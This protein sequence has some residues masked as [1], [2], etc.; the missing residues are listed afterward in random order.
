MRQIGFQMRDSVVGSNEELSETDVRMP[1]PLPFESERIRIGTDGEGGASLALQDGMELQQAALWLGEA[2]ARD[3][4]LLQVLDSVT[5]NA[6]TIAIHV[7]PALAE[8]ELCRVT[9]PW[10]LA[11]VESRD[12]RVI[13]HPSGEAEIKFAV[14]KL[15]LASAKDSSALVRLRKLLESAEKLAEL[16]T[17]AG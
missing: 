7:P 3:P 12:G 5:S 6:I 13:L 9:D 1:A 15:G 11:V 8:S 17:R 10:E 2:A 16:I 4:Q 14:W